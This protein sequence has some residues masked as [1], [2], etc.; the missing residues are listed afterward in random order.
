MFLLHFVSFFFPVGVIKNGINTDNSHNN[1]YNTTT[2]SHNKAF[3]LNF[4]LN[5][6]CKNAMNI[7]DFVDSIQLNLSDLE[8]VGDVGFVKGIS[9]IIIKN[10]NALDVTERPIHCTDKKREVLYVKDENKWEKEDPD[11]GKVRKVIKKVAS[12]NS[13]ILKDF[14]E[15]YP[16]CSQSISKFADRYNKLIIEAFGGLGNDI[17]ENENKIIKNISKVITIHKE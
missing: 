8:R 9:D 12:K 2:N 3:N 14:K 5:E 15:K 10:L 17:R 7:N 13:K 4:F 6:T 16:D 11:N 1:S